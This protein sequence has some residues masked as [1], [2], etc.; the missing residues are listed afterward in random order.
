MASV[1]GGPAAPL[2]AVDGAQLAVRRRPLVPDVDL[3]LDQPVD[4]RRA[5]EEPEQ[6]SEDSAGEDLLRGEQRKAGLQIEAHLIAEDAARP[7]SGPIGLVDA[8]IENMLQQIKILLHDVSSPRTS[9]SCGTIAR[10]ARP[11]WLIASFCSAVI[12]AVVRGS[13]PGSSS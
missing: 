6:F 1:G 8:V 2:V 9:S 12:C 13:A 3:V 11:R 7:C 10:N 5:L 4:I